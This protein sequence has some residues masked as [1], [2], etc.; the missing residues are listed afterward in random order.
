[1]EIN[2]NKIYHSNNSGDFKIIENIG[3]NENHRYL[4]KIKFIDTGTEKIVRYDHVTKGNIRDELYGIDFNKTYI[5]NAGYTYKIIEFI[6]MSKDSKKLVKI[7]FDNTGTEKIVYLKCAIK[8]SV[9][10]ELHFINFNR[11]Y[12]S[13][14]YGSFKII[15]I[16]GNIKNHIRVLIKFTN[17]GYEKDVQIENVKTG[18]VKDDIATFKEYITIDKIGIDEYNIR[19]TNILKSIWKSMISRCNNNKSNA[20]INYGLIGVSVCKRWLELD[21]FLDDAKYIDGFDKFYNRPFL[22]ELD[23]DY[24][25]IN[26]PKSQRIYSKETCTF[27]YYMDN[28]N[29]KTIEYKRDNNLSSEYFGIMK[30]KQNTYKCQIM[31]N[32]TSF[33]LG[34]FDNEIAAAN[35]FNN[36]VL[37]YKNYELV[38]LLNDVP[39]MSPQEITSHNINLKIVCKLVE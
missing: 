32:G 19:I 10:D 7:R 14:Q 2:M 20:Y 36:A 26:I 8:G 37:L 27:L 12:W 25:Q 38:P 11:L 15:S 18:Q 5:A 13:N 30:T 23:K 21:N 9:Y 22:Y 39:Y 3:Y 33:K 6:D 1:M 29:L 31:I 34:I 4:V 35:A 17:T 24:K 16:I 28:L